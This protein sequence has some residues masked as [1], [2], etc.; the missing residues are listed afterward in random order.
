[1]TQGKT[2][3]IISGGIEAADAAQRAKQMGLT[4]VVSD[5]DPQAPGFAFADSCLIA[6]VYGANETA[7]AAERYNRKIRKIDGVLCVAADAPVTAATVAQRLRLPGLPIHVAELACDK[8]AMKRCFQSA[9]VAVPWFAEVSTPQELQRIAIERGRDLVIKPVDS[10]GSRGV[11]RVAQVEDLAGAFLLAR[12]HS[13]SER[14]MVEQYLPGP[15]VSTESIVIDGVC[16]TP[17]FSDRNYEY[18]DRYAPFFIENGG[19]LPSLLPDAIQ[20]KVRDLVGRAAAAM[21][22]THGTVKGDVVVHQGEPYMIELA[23]RLS[24]GFFCTREIPLN[25]GVDFIGAAIRLA[26]GEP[27]AAEELTPRYQQPVVQ[28]YAFPAPGTVVSI[29]GADDARKIAGIE[30]V[31]VTA[32]PGDIIPPAGDKRPSA[33][34]VLATGATRDAALAAANDALAAL[35]I[36]TS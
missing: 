25:T 7:A 26:L 30:E 18:L 5:R 1:M 22:V 31:V 19:D 13:P 24:G 23:A 36:Q 33:A 34:M 15:Q 21:G 8:L 12:G 11:Q 16:H 28:R 20:D 6:D 35:K 14:V 27:V 2:L 32:N 3:L 29:A 17:G 9:G 10:R 4:V